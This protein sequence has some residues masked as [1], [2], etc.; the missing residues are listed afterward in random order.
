[1]PIFEADIGGQIYEIDAKDEGELQSAINMIMQPQ[2]AAPQETYDPTAGMST[3]EKLM[4]G[5]GK[6]VYDI[7]R[8]IGQMTGLMPQSAIDEARARDAAL[9]QTGA[10]MAGNVLGNIATA[11]IPGRA[12]MAAPGIIGKAGT[13][14][15]APTSF[16]QAAAGGAMMG[17][18]QPA[19]TGESRL[20]NIGESALGGGLGYGAA[21]GLGRV[22]NPQLSP[23]AQMLMSSGVTPTP[24]QIMGGAANRI[25][26]GAMSVPILGDAITA[27]RQQA[28]SQF[29]VA[30]GDEVLSS[31]GETVPRNIPPGND[32]VR[33]IGSRLS[34]KYDSL[35]PTMSARIDDQFKSELRK[36][37]EMANSLPQDKGKQ[38]KKLLAQNVEQR[39]GKSVGLRGETIK[40]IQS[41]LTKKASQYRSSG[42]PDQRAIG[43]ALNEASRSMRELI[44]RSNPDKAAE[45][46]AIDQA[47]MKLT[48]LET[49]AQMAGSQGGVFSPEAFRS[50]VRAGDTSVRNRAFAQG[51]APMQELAQSGVDVLGRT[52]PDSG[53]AYR[54]ATGGALFGG[55]LAVDPLSAAGALGAAGM[56]ASP[57]AR[58]AMNAAL[59]SRPEAMRQLGLLSQGLAPASG[60]IGSASAR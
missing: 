40:E 13:A 37:K 46:S 30:V 31:I 42:D 59:F 4:A 25:E 45:L 7:G 5:A 33:Y 44:K 32:M 6:A 21:A 8:G 22:M 16:G 58:G 15:A 14:L 23:E 12:L 48:R 11:A 17:A 2:Q 26:Q 55:L 41:S 18:L 38:L 56:Y 3:G 36:L 1:M 60:V 34:N 52:V 35:L 57:A 47:Y 10:G 39:I 53:T 49:A 24:G 50:A 51:R 43:D 27:A 54:L 29:N 28:G 20:E 19:V 9:M